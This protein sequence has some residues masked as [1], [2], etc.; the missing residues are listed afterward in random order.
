MV[1]PAVLRHLYSNSIIVIVAYAD[2]L[3]TKTHIVVILGVG[4]RASALEHIV[5]AIVEGQTAHEHMT[6]LVAVTVEA[7]DRCAAVVAEGYAVEGIV[8]ALR[9]ATCAVAAELDAVAIARERHI[10]RFVDIFLHPRMVCGL[11]RLPLP[12]LGQHNVE[13]GLVEIPTIVAIVPGAAADEAIALAVVHLAGKS[14]S[15]RSIVSV[16]VAVV[17]RVAVYDIIVGTVATIILRDVGE[18]VAELM[19]ETELQASIKVIR[20]LAALYAVV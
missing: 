19:A 5:V 3:S 16:I 17:V 11:A 9:R 12:A 13:V 20:E 8:H 18:G 2:F 4:V 15:I 6:V 10:A 7:L 1:G 14:I